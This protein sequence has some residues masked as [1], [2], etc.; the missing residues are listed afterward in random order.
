MKSSVLL[1]IFYQS[2]LK[3]DIAVIKKVGK[4]KHEYRVQEAHRSDKYV[5][6]M[7]RELLRSF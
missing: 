3:L 7:V 1:G 5:P 4:I 2:Q 6:Y